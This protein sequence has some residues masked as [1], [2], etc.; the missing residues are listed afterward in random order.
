MEGRIEG[1]N[2]KP[3]GVRGCLVDPAIW[4]VGVEGF[5]VLFGGDL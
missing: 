2:F 5:L 1:R 3:G 4:V